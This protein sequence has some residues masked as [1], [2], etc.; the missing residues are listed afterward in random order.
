MIN[1]R[2][3]VN[4]GMMETRKLFEGSIKEREKKYG[5]LI[6]A[7]LL[8]VASFV[9]AWYDDMLFDHFYILYLPVYPI[10]FGCFIALLVAN[11]ISIAKNK[12]Y[13]NFI[14]ITILVLLVVTIIFFP[15][16]YAKVR[17]E[18][19]LFDKDRMEIVDMIKNGKL[20]P[21]SGGNVTLPAGY[22]KLSSDATV[23]VYRN[24]EEGQVIGFW[25]FRGMLSGSTHL[26]Y[27]SDHEELIRKTISL[28][29]KILKLD[30]LKENWYYVIME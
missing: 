23:Y 8:F 20:K 15:F 13:I 18:L 4:R 2:I 11:I 21:K 3:E 17:V 10:L 9:V 7:T 22:G 28:N 24:D 26:M 1:D 25:A 29:A 27:S 5:L 12:K 6:L 14:S 16:R 30:E 19:E